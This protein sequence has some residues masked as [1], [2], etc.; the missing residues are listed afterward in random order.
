MYHL[1]FHLGLDECEQSEHQKHHDNL[2]VIVGSVR[3]V[4]SD[5]WVFLF[6]HNVADEHSLIFASPRALGPSM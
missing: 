3:R 1:D 6:T 4:L 2:D 5:V